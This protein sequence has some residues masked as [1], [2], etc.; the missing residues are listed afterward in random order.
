MTRRNPAAALARPLGH[1]PQAKRVDA[2][3]EHY[4]NKRFARLFGPLAGSGRLGWHNPGLRRNALGFAAAL[5]LPFGGDGAGA[6]A[7]TR[8]SEGRCC[9][10]GKAATPNSPHPVYCRAIPGCPSLSA[11]AAGPRPGASG[12]SEGRV[13]SSGRTADVSIM[14]PG[15]DPHH[16]G[17]PLARRAYRRLPGCPRRS[18]IRRLRRLLRVREGVVGTEIQIQTPLIPSRRACAPYRGI[19]PR[20]PGR[21]GS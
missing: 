14:T 1:I 4:M 6:A 20:L 21:T 2:R 13:A 11:R 15:L 16:A 19:D 10:S 7:A 5:G 8:G 9:R 17:A 18:S 12:Q 3:L